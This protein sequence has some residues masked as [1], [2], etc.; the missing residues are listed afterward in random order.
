MFKVQYISPEYYTVELNCDRIFHPQTGEAMRMLKLK[1]NDTGPVL[2]PIVKDSFGRVVNLQGARVKFVM[3]AEDKVLGPEGEFIAVSTQDVVTIQSQ[4]S[5]RTEGQF[6]VAL[7]EEHTC[8]SGKFNAEFQVS[9][10][11]STKTAK[12]PPFALNDGDTLIVKVDGTEQT[13]TFNN[14]DFSSI[15]QATVPEVVAKLNADLSGATAYEFKILEDPCYMLL[16]SDNLVDGSLEISG[17]TAAET[18][19]FD[20]TIHRAQKITLPH[21]RLLVHIE[22]DLD[23]AE[24]IE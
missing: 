2:N 10:A 17:G 22:D 8:T 4:L 11:A 9:L 5:N 12:T 3:K 20:T 13:I 24:E 18:L 14:Q 1:R 19:G 23:E 21:E 7:K 6:H 16:S 15:G